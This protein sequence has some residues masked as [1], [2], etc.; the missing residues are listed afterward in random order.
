VRSRAVK[1][2]FMIVACL[3]LGWVVAD[4][5]YTV[6][7]WRDRVE[8]AQLDYQELSGAAPEFDLLDMQGTHLRLSDLRG[9]VVL[10][11]FWFTECSP[12]RRELP[13]LISLMGQLAD[14]DDFVLLAVSVD[15]SWDKVRAFGD[16]YKGMLSSAGEQHRFAQQTVAFFSGS[17]P[18][19][20]IL[21]D[22]DK[23]TPTAY[24]TRLFPETY[25]IGRDGDLLYRF[26]GD[27]EWNSDDAVRFFSRLLGRG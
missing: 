19:M 3:G 13:S 21:L 18:R 2:G 26:V 1:I 17:N 10:L 15:D 23:A 6:A 4:R 25:V 14:R 5:I 9:K 27:R 7:T 8:H 12:C 16:W 22:P 24:G 11:N 20:R